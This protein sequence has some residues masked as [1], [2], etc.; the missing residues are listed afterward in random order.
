[1]R[2]PFSLPRALRDRTL[3]PDHY[4]WYVFAATLDIVVT[5]VIV[6]GLGG[7]EVNRIASS[8]LERF[9]HWGLIGLK[10]A[11]VI[12]VV[13]ICEAVGRKNVGWGRRLVVAAVV[14][15]ALPVGVGILQVLAWM[16]LGWFEPALAAQ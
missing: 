12:L 5:Y 7:R 16:H 13:F 1:M 6:W 14:L 11:S 10:F 8:L 2:P 9:D 15:S 3:Y 4:V